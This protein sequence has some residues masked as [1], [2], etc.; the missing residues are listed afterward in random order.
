MPLLDD[1]LATLTGGES[2]PEA[3]R[4]EIAQ[5]LACAE[6]GELVI[7]EARLL[8]L[9]D[10]HPDVAAVFL[11]LGEVR[12]RRGHDERAV[13]A[14]GRAVNLA[15]NAVDGW[16]GLGEA[17]VRLGRPEPA[18]DALRRVLSGTT[19]AALVGRAHAARARLALLAGR[20]GE[21][22][23]ELRKATEACPRD[24]AMAAELGRALL[25]AGDQ[26]GWRWLVH[27]AQDCIDGKGPATRA[28][29]DL[30]I[31]AANTCPEHVAA[32]NL[33]RSGLAEISWSG[34]LRARLHAA[35]A[36]RLAA[37]GQGDEARALAA[38]ALAGNPDDA[39]VLAAWRALAESVGDFSG[40]LAAAKRE[41][42]LGSPA[43][44]ATLVRLALAAQSLPD[45]QSAQ[46]RLA[47]EASEMGAA[48][49]AWLNGIARESDVLALAPLAAGETAR[50]F[51]A[52]AL[53][54]VAPPAGNLAGLLAHA[55]ELATHTPELQSL[56][57]T[58]MRAAEALQR[59]LRVAV[60]GEF[61]AGK[62]SFVNALCGAEIARVGVTP[63]TATINLLRFGEPGGRVHFQDGRVEDRDASGIRS[64]VAGLDEAAAGAV[65][66]VEIFHPLPVLQKTEV[67]D[68]P[69]TNSLR[70]EHEKVARAFLAE[71]DAIV[72]VF[73]LAQAGK[74]SERGVLELA[75]GAGKRVLGV[76]NKADQA[77]PDEVDQVLTHLGRT[78]GDRI[79]ALLPLSA[80]NALAAHLAGD[81]DRWQGTGMPAV[82]AALQERFFQH[83]ES[84]KQ[85]TA[86]AALARFVA[87]A[88]SLAQP[89]PAEDWQRRRAELDACEARVNAALA[90]ERL[91]L[92]ANLD[93]GFRRAAV[94][95]LAQARPRVWPLGEPR[96]LDADQ[97]YLLDL[98]EEAIASAT[99][100][101]KAAL[102]AEAADAP[103]LPIA[104]MVE[105]FAAYAR[106]M[107]AGCLAEDFLRQFL[108]RPGRVDAQ[109]A[110][111]AL[112]RHL[113]DAEAELFSP[114]AAKLREAFAQARADVARQ[115]DRQA[116]AATLLEAR[117]TRP[118]AELR[119]CL[120]PD[121]P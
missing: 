15:K 107:L 53:A 65:R 2:L 77:S 8:G 17:L 106:G 39:F 48:L 74:Q 25:V 62:S 20:A 41:A 14:Y 85:R 43:P 5:A 120:Q 12:V 76:L 99:A 3:V 44:A 78:L 10:D 112:T 117:L 68:T 31:E 83:A 113:P 49:A 37:A 11:A 121:E 6:D 118:L 35:L 19:E 69:G 108:S 16:L 95:T 52:R 59:P 70:P 100:A 97:E 51:L 72:W 36:G 98:L 92:P 26:E 38:Q 101:S 33:L 32:H 9:A 29:A 91:N 110:A 114:L 27:A 80:R 67:V 4:K 82:H 88:E 57:P 55:C 23:R 104:P 86:R 84:L 56:L 1:I 94:E 105:M 64:F 90:R 46:E 87:E 71:A 63:T 21:A 22:V 24:R 47:S 40:A 61:N 115:A 75:H 89:A 103:P 109:A 73:S 81:Q 45:L 7:A 111:A 34:E 79:E 116:M 66:M 54:P 60:M 42:E 50:G 96:A 28:A 30:I 102:L 119:A 58:A 13:E 18:R 93:D